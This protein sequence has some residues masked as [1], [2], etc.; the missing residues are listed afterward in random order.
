[1]SSNRATVVVLYPC[2][3]N[4]TFKLDYYLSTHMPLA[5]RLWA[6][7]GL[8]SWSVTQLSEDALHSIHVP[9]EWESI[10][11]FDIALQNTGTWEVRADVENFSSEEPIL[12]QGN[13]I[14]QG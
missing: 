7:Y 11:S 4:S 3:I 9:M 5:A 1:M 12:I 6:R 8:K 13:C 14:G 2:T 10:E